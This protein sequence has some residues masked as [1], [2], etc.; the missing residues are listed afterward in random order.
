[1]GPAAEGDGRVERQVV[2]SVDQAVAAVAVA[3]AALG[4][5]VHPPGRRF[6]GEAVRLAARF[7]HELHTGTAQLH[8]WGGESTVMLPPHPGRGVRNLH[9][10]R[11]AAR[12]IAGRTVQILLPARTDGSERV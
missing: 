8:V 9:L 1:M 12:H 7:A 6:A 4:L 3:A 10:T 11:A 5:T 2:A